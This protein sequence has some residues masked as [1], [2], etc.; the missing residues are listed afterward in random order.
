MDNPNIPKAILKAAL[1]W[2]VALLAGLLLK[3][4]G[5]GRVVTAAASGAAGGLAALAI[6]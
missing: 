4:L 3:A 5:A 2:F 6:V 1:A